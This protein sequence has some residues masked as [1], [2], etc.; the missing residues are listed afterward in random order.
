MLYPMLFFNPG[1]P[2]FTPKPT[3]AAWEISPARN[4]LPHPRPPPH[5]CLHPAC[6]DPK[7]ILR[8]RRFLQEA[9]PGERAGSRHPSDP[10]VPGHYLARP[11]P[12]GRAAPYRKGVC[13]GPLPCR[14]SSRGQKP[15]PAVSI[16]PQPHARGLAP[17][18]H[19][20]Q[21]LTTASPLL[22]RVPEPHVRVRVCIPNRL[23]GVPAKTPFHLALRAEVKQMDLCRKCSLKC[24]TCRS[25]KRRP[26]LG[27]FQKG[28]SQ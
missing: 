16:A 26:L 24:I 2:R 14:L 22:P 11:K 20:A 6:R 27:E 9:R 28:A 13:F 7:P 18:R 15:S 23:R 5:V 3:Y 12:A 1:A 8:V 19:S 4:E 10:E 25:L 21:V 17:S